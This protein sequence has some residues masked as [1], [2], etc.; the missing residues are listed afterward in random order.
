MH[1][2]RTWGSATRGARDVS[3]RISFDQIAVVVCFVALIA[4]VVLGGALMLLS[5]VTATAP[6]S[7]QSACSEPNGCAGTPTEKNDA[8]LVDNDW[9]YGPKLTR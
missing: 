7:P 4:I 1:T 3:T 2:E 9:V 5:W 6:A 8:V